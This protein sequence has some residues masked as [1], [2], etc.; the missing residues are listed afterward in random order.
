M[1]LPEL[2]SG[3]P[4]CYPAIQLERLAHQE[5]RPIPPPRDSAQAESTKDVGSILAPEAMA[6][7][8]AALAGNK[9]ESRTLNSTQERRFETR[10][11]V[12]KTSNGSFMVTHSPHVPLISTHRSS[13]PPRIPS[14]P[15]MGLPGEYSFFTTPERRINI[16]NA[17]RPA[18]AHRSPATTCDYLVQSG[19]GKYRIIGP[20]GHRVVDEHLTPF[21]R[22]HTASIVSQ[23]AHST[24]RT[25]VQQVNISQRPSQPFN[26]TKIL[27]L[28][29][30]LHIYSES[31]HNRIPLLP[32]P[33][34][35]KI[36][37]KPPPQSSANTGLEAKVENLKSRFI[38]Q[39]NHLPLSSVDD[40]FSK[41]KGKSEAHSTLRAPLKRRKTLT[42]ATMTDAEL[43]SSSANQA[44]V[45][46]LL[47]AVLSIGDPLPPEST[48]QGKG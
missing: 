25:V 48:L 28:A 13:F 42:P 40:L 36:P 24:E 22:K 14:Q 27:P 11:P 10:V 29:P 44:G 30:K 16:Q 37:E 4:A 3:A 31:P 15:L 20:D 45:D 43:R 34:Q 2:S 35:Q 39:G 47:K 18:T 33:A 1:L 6:A 7:L 8:R 32:P 19:T 12:I 9:P 26:Q 46:V 5:R 38:G 21:E 17:T 41:S 23:P